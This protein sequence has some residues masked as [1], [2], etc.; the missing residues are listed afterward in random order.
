MLA[1]LLDPF[2]AHGLGNMFLGKFLEVL[3]CPAVPLTR[4]DAAAHNWMV[5]QEHR[6]A[7]GRIDILLLCPEKAL[8]IAIEN[9]IDAKESDSQLLCYYDWLETLSLHFKHRRLV[10]LTLKGIRS[11]RVGGDACTALAYNSILRVL[12]ECLAAVPTVHPALRTYANTLATLTGAEQHQ[13]QSSD[14]KSHELFNVFRFLRLARREAVLHTRM[15]A[16]LLQPEESAFG[17]GNHFLRFLLE[18]LLGRERAAEA[19]KCKW[20]IEP[21][22]EVD[23]GR[24]DILLRCEN[25][26]ILIAIEKKIDAALG[27]SQLLR[28]HRWMSTQSG[29]EKRILVFLTLDGSEPPAEEKPAGVRLLSY[30]EI[31][32]MIDRCSSQAASEVVRQVLEQYVAVL[33]GIVAR[34]ASSNVRIGRRLLPPAEYSRAALGFLSDLV[35]RWNE[36]PMRADKERP[37]EV[38]HLV[39]RLAPDDDYGGKY[40]KI[41]VW[42]KELLLFERQQIVVIVIET[43]LGNRQWMGLRLGLHW[44]NTAHAA[45]NSRWLQLDEAND[46]LRLAGTLYKVA[47]PLRK[48]Q[49][50]AVEERLEYPRSDAGLVSVLRHHGPELQ[51]VIV[52]RIC[53]IWAFCGEK[54][55]RLNRKLIAL[56]R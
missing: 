34:T 5:K 27:P 26:G 31:L 28:Y 56:Q 41:E 47:E 55:L 32:R 30:E 29:Y 25:N 49:W 52:S 54:V 2:G 50:L 19:A 6:I 24:I 1:G 12:K 44:R 43:N 53:N 48:G 36:L 4:E 40:H 37:E 51:Q 3:S 17:L 22:V 39:P 21:E 15:L 7:G 42:H 23:S 33:R 16:R 9:K 38:K 14:E 20:H 45:T 13:W 35:A 18:L 8:A 46:L 10:F 11:R